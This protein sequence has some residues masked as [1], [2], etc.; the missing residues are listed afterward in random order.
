L[1]TTLIKEQEAMLEI[2]K[3]L[4]GNYLILLPDQPRFTIVEVSHD[5]NLATLTNREDIIGSGIFE[6]L[7]DDPNDAD[8][9][10]VNNLSASFAIVLQ[11]KE[12][13]EMPVQ[14]YP[15]PVPG[16]NEFI[17]KFWFPVNKPVVVNDKIVY[18]IHTVTDVTESKQI[19]AREQYFKTL[20]DE[21][22]FMIWRSAG[23]SC[24]YV[25]TSWIETT[26]LSLAESLGSGFLKA[27]HP[28]DIAEQH[29][30]FANALTTN[31]SY[32]TKFKLIAKNGTLIWVFMKVT[33]HQLSEGAVEYIGSLID[34]TRQE[35]AAQHIL[36]SEMQFRQLADSIIQMVWITDPQ[37]MHEYYNQRWY[38][39]TGTTHDETGGEGWNHVFHPDD[40]QRAWQLWS[41]SLTTGD[42]YEIEYRL[43]KYTGE[44]IWVLGRAAPF[45]DVNGEIIRWFGTCTDINEQKLLQ[46]QK[47]EFINIASH[48]LK[49]PL[50]GLKAN[51]Q[52]LERMLSK[53]TDAEPML[54]KL[55]NS[56]HKNVDKLNNLIEELLDANT[57]GL[58]QLK[59]EK[60]WFDL[61]ALITESVNALSTLQQPVKVIGIN[62]LQIH[63]DKGKIERVITNLIN[64]AHKYGGE[65][66]PVEIHI[67]ENENLVT[68]SVIDKG[69][70]IPEDKQQFIFDRYYQVEGKAGSYS[71]MG[72]G[73]YICANI[74]KSHNGQIGLESKLSEG[75]TFWF[76]LPKFGH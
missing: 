60:E 9:N 59:I 12:R 61:I 14:R 30:F 66:A 15:V 44:Y 52:L 63:A 54:N 75:S 47:D 28:D 23:A 24:M 53:R 73:L 11:T 69:R 43:R 74:I 22:P 50:T 34:I 64:N 31:A 65:T 7:P 58:G 42:P 10:G 57:I 13:H 40:Q 49:T 19:K 51:I 27:F 29:K 72:L 33:P 38:D 26:G 25:N 67:T 55:V 37:G 4:P 32:E 20:A 39:F 71:G 35:I 21:S 70:G 45:Y 8:A 46:Q 18:I 36:E 41:H 1:K 68:V 3:G 5:Y 6:V 56:S 76:T 2:I 17:E 16:T 62:S 48:E